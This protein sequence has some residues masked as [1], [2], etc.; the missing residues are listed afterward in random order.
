MHT[1]EYWI[2]NLQLLPHPEGGFYKETYRSD[3]NITSAELAGRFDGVRSVS[4]AIY[5][6]LR[7]QDMSSFHRIKSDELWHF[8][9]GSPLTIY[10]LHTSGLSLYKLGLDTT[11]GQSPQ[12]TIPAQCW[13][14][15][16][17]DM[18]DAY[19]VVSCTVAPGFHFHD[20]E[21]AKR[22]ALLQKFPDHAALIKRLTL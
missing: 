22:D 20:F 7:S 4:T 18:P 10:A 6:L 3:E 1:A 15:A 11:S 9:E 16:T 8:H 14:G 19:T 12:V 2:E 17:V 21:L 5:F 13:F